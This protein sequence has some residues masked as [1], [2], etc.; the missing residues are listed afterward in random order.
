MNIYAKEGDKVVCSTL[1]GGYKSDQET[2]EKY[3]VIGTEYTI[4]YT[5][6]DNW[7]TD[8]YLGEFPGINFNSVFFE[9]V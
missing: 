8:V 5:D 9:N 2:A 1:D 6:V 7:H 3:L 4:E